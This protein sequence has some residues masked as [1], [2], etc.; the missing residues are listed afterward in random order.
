MTFTFGWAGSRKVSALP[1]HCFHLRPVCL[2]VDWSHPRP[3]IPVIA[4]HSN[5]PHS[6][7]LITSSSKPEHCWSRACR[8]GGEG[9]RS[10]QKW[11][12]GE[13]YPLPRISRDLGLVY[14]RNKY[15]HFKLFCMVWNT[16][17]AHKVVLKRLKTLKFL[18]KGKGTSLPLDRIPWG[19][20]I[21]PLGFIAN[22]DFWSLPPLPPAIGLILQKIGKN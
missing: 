16:K 22:E 5:G 7:E 6:H 12:F 19:L 11:F 2:D 8:G 17:K 9:D 3:P 18:A 21:G 10:P 14:F 20:M 1:E 4:L 15:T 13:S